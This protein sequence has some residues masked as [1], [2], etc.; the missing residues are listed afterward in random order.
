MVDYESKPFI[1]SNSMQGNSPQNQKRRYRGKLRLLEVI[2]LLPLTTLVLY[3]IV[4]TVIG[5]SVGG[6]T[7][8]ILLGIFLFLMGWFPLVPNS[9]AIV[10]FLLGMAIYV[11]CLWA[12]VLLSNETLAARKPTALGVL[13]GILLGAL[14]IVAIMAVKHDFS[15]APLFWIGIFI[16]PFGIALHQLDRLRR[17]SFNDIATNRFRLS[18]GI[19]AVITLMV[20]VLMT[21]TPSSSSPTSVTD[22]RI[23]ETPSDAEIRAMADGAAPEY[24]DIRYKA[25]LANIEKSKSISD[26][27]TEIRVGAYRY[28]IPM[29]YLTPWGDFKGQKDFQYRG[30]P[31]L[32]EHKGEKT[33]DSSGFVM[34]LPDFRGYDRKNFLDEFHSDRIDVNWSAE[35]QGTTEVETRLNNRIKFKMMEPMPS[36]SRH[37]LKGY[38][39]LRVDINKEVWVATNRDG[40]KIAIQCSL[41]TPNRLCQV[42]YHHKPNQYW[43][44]YTYKDIHLAKWREIDTNINRLLMS[45]RVGELGTSK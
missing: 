31:K 9:T 10:F 35:E 32:F 23:L 41:D 24:R 33:F 18:I 30:P 2:A 45:W 21:N 40:Q 27:P 13:L 25:L 34:F 29:N 3:A 38:K 1:G 28:Q 15:D 19:L 4:M 11:L 17:V 39:G 20:T 36:L 26:T 8:P 6:Q 16:L 7:Q 12:A 42:Q 44:S 5:F 14:M 43:L 22:P 37:G